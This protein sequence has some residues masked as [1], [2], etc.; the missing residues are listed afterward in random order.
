MH[1]LVGLV[2][3]LPVLVAEFKLRASFLLEGPL[4]RIEFRKSL[5]A[6]LAVVIGAFVDRDLFARLPAKE[7]VIAVRAE[8]F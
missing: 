3:I 2:V 4:S 5:N 1:L 8:V 6:V 7:G